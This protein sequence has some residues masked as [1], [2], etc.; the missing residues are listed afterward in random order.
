MTDPTQRFSS[1]VENYIKFRPGYPPAVLELLARKCGL[2]GTSVVADVGSGTGILTGLLLQSGGRIFAVE[3]NR[4][5]REAAEKLLGGNPNFTSVTG[6]AETTWLPDRSMDVITAGQA[7]HWFD[8]AR[9]RPE[10]LRILKPGGWVVLIWNDRNITA[11]PFFRAYEQLLLTFGTDYAAVNHKNVD[12]QVL[13]SFFGPKGYGS[14][15]FPNDQTFDFDGLKG[16]LLSSSYAPE[17]GDPR[18]VPMLE[19]LESLFQTYQTHG[20]V[21]FDYDTTVFYG[22]LSAG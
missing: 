18:H 21:T 2:T 12:E 1:R 10:F 20:K 11:H 5:M 15:S 4:E 7:F 14:A 22:R 17:P 6:S 3:P 13:G 16:R 19:A 8:R 9:M